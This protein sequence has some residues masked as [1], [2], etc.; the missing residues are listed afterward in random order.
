[1]WLLPK[2]HTTQEG[3]KGMRVNSFLDRDTKDPL[4]DRLHVYADIYRP[5]SSH[6]TQV[7]AVIAGATMENLALA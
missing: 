2:E 6:E 4:R 5:A 3:R 1:M 7:P